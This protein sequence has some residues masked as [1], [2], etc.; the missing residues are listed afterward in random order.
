MKQVR[1]KN[2]RLAVV[3]MLLLLV[4]SSF[5]GL[6][7]YSV[8][9]AQAVNAFT[10]GYGEIEIEEDF[11][12]PAK[13]LPGITIRKEVAVVN[14][15]TVPCRVRLLA[16]YTSSQ[17]AALSVVDFDREHWSETGDYFY[18]KYVLQ[19]GEKTAPLFSEIKISE[20]ASQSELE[21][22]DILIYGE[23]I[24]ENG[25]LWSEL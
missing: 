11:E 3:L 15:G 8:Y 5:L 16:K 20:A 13:M 21:P 18:Y 10:V 23:A 25:L 19:P 17:M 1:F 9:Q 22:F 6:L 12:P 7:A 4:N 24:Q 14:T 2:R